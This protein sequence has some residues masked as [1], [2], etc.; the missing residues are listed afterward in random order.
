MLRFGHETRAIAG[1]CLL[2]AVVH[3]WPL[4]TAP[5]TLSRNDN[6]DAELNEWILA[7][8]AHQL[9]RAPA[10]LFEGNI[11]YPERDSLAFSEPLIVPA[12]MGA[13]LHWIGASPV[14][15]FNVVLLLG[16]ALTAWAGYALA[17][18]W[19]GDRTAGVL[20]G[21]M[22]AFNTHTLTRLAHV[23]G[24]HAWGLPL[25]LLSADRILVHARWRDAIWLAVWMTAMAYTSGYLIVFGAVM[26]A[27]VVAAR[28]PDWWPR[29]GRTAMLL[30]G[31]T[32][33]SAAAVLP[34]YLPYRR[35]A[36]LGMVRP[37]D[38]VAE[39]SA[40]LKGYFAAAGRIHFS[41]WSA[42]FWENPVDA[43]FPGFVVFALAIAALYWALR[44]PAADHL[45]R[46][47]IV[48]LVAIAATGVLLSL[49]TRTPVYG[50]V[51]S[52]FPPMQGLRA[53]SRFGNLFL[54]AMAMLAA[55]GLVNLRRRLPERRAT[56]VVVGLVIL[57][58]VESLR[59]PFLYT[60]FE[61]IPA[62]YSLLAHEPGRVVLVEVPFYPPQAVFENG[63]YVLNST[64][65]WR[66]LMNGYSGYTPGAYR[67]YA[68]TFWYFPQEHAIQA[69]RKA[70]A[71][72]V[73]IHPKAFGTEAEIEKMW[74][75]VAA[76][77]YL[78]RIAT[79]PRGPALYRLR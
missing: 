16:F 40:T 27:V 70:G 18:D 76:S 35:V 77:P 11:F 17:V 73:M 36:K 49:G 48:M 15:V 45:T 37:I 53:A 57:A 29:L 2:L 71:T 60:R 6:A 66:P 46:R 24:I 43:F 61:G 51:Y 79:T 74:Q 19:T 20:A 42:R 59:A 72:H 62:I 10:R 52:I 54:V 7:W 8:V 55:F 26:V 4:A 44:L 56:L 78:E 21:S 65:H 41:T 69:M 58:N 34:M 32:L 1:L 50:W 22:F 47:R 75:A 68:A 23:Q 31:A 28:A 38:T 3:T 33:L 12:L 39:F 67:Q 14:F 25:A 64:A 30:G 9:P 63:T 5:G 13:P